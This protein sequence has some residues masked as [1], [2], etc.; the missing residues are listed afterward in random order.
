MSGVQIPAVPIV[1]FIYE[2]GFKKIVTRIITIASGKG[3]VGKT[4]VTVNLSHALY[5]LNKDVTIIDA[6]L[7]SPNIYLHMNI[8]I[9]P[10]TL[11]DAMKGKISIKEAVYLHYLG[12]KVIPASISL[13][14]LKFK[15]KKNL[16]NLI[17]DLIGTSDFILIDAPPGLNEDTID[18][19]DAGNELL[20]VTNPELPATVEALR[21]IEFTR[22]NWAKNI[23]VILNRYSGKSWE[24]RPKHIESFLEA[25]IISIIPEDENVK[26]AIV[27]RIPVVEAYPE[28]KAASAFMKL[29]EK[30]LGIRRVKVRKES[31][32]SRILRFLG[33]AR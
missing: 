18:A 16:T 19:L 28:S 15:E 17:V 8:P 2:V 26:K 30:L 14:D 32:I 13:R 12:V 3:G 25:P 24:L 5:K 1:K 10:T 27:K 29:A 22:R 7:T 23:N 6:N 20:V 33:L 21:V 9:T 31:A 4:T 11:H